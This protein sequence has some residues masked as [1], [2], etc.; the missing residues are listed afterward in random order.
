MTKIIFDYVEREAFN[1]FVNAAKLSNRVE[2]HT[3]VDIINIYLRQTKH[4]ELS[5]VRIYE[6]STYD[7]VYLTYYYVKNDSYRKLEHM[8]NI[9]K[10]IQEH[11][12]LVD[13]EEFDGGDMVRL[14]MISN[15]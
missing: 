5:D 8:A 13:F 1:R 9:E 11:Y 15:D 3:Y 7:K 4:E 10:I 2:N 14:E 12:H 6:T